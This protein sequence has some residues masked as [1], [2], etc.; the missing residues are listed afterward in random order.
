MGQIHLCPLLRGPPRQT[1]SNLMAMFHSM[2][3]TPTCQS[4]PKFAFNMF[5]VLSLNDATSKNV[6]VLKAP[7]KM[8]TAPWMDGLRRIIKWGEVQSINTVPSIL[9]LAYNQTPYLQFDYG[10]CLQAIY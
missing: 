9:C 3:P 6:C 10:A 8:D 7:S 2:N 1:E 4:F 5:P